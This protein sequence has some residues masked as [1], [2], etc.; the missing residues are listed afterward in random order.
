MIVTAFNPETDNLERSYLSTDHDAGLTTLT[1]K[2]NDKIL[3][4]KRIM[5]G[6]MGHERTEVRTTGGPTGTTQIAV[7]AATSFAHDTDDPVM[8]LAYDQIAFYRS[9][10]KDGVY[11]LLTTVGIDVDNADGVTRYDDTGGSTTDYYKVKYVNSISLEDTEFSDPI[12]ATGFAVT[13][14]GKV[15]DQVVRRVRDQSYSVLGP[16][17][18]LDIMNEVNNDLITQTHRPYRFLKTY[19]DLDTVADQ[20][21]IALPDDLWKFDRVEYTRTLGGQTRIYTYRKPLT[22]EAFD[23]RYRSSFWTSSDELRDIYVDEVEKKLYIGPSPKTSQTGKV[24][25][26]YWKTFDEITDVGDAVETPNTLIYRYKMLA[27]YY[28]AKSESDNQFARLANNYEQ[29]Y[30][31]EVVKMQRV[32]RLDAGTPREMAPPDVGYRKRY[33]L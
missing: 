20:N 3:T 15:I 32:N 16:E 5:I 1:V 24:R 11:S 14:A 9:A 12:P 6:E 23:R 26:Y 25:L 2:N 30:G 28:S 10:S 7:T 17:E 27:E 33:V 4:S 19:A 29:K 22:G 21:Y 13:T 31:A 8:V 18:Y